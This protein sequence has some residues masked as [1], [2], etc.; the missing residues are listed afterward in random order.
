MVLS[1]AFDTVDHEILLSKLEHYGVRGTPLAWFKNYLTDRQQIV[2]YNSTFSKSET[3]KCGVPQAWVLGPLLFLINKN[4][5]YKS[6]NLIKYILFTNDTNM[7]SNTKILT[8][9][10][11][12]IESITMVYF[13]QITY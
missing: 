2:K 9:W 3:I 12:L 10:Y 1:K 5:I 7:F 4:D 13:K 8:N 11:Q 6:S